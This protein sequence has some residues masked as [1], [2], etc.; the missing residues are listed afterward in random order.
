LQGIFGI[1]E[2]GYL[3]SALNKWIHTVKDER[4]RTKIETLAEMV[5]DGEIDEKKFNEKVVALFKQLPEE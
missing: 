5:E 1:E 2:T 3:Y 4:I